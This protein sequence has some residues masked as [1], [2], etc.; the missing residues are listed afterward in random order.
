L[1]DVESHG[2]V[3][4]DITPTLPRSVEAGELPIAVAVNA[5]DSEPA[6]RKILIRIASPDELK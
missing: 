4:L 6:Q 3:K 1:P 2:P 5:S